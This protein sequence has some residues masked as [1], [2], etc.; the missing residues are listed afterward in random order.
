[1]RG[2]DEHGRGRLCILGITPAH[3]G[4]SC[5]RTSYLLPTRDHPRA[6]GEKASPKNVLRSMAGSPPRMRGKEAA[7]GRFGGSSGIT[8]A[9]AGKRRKRGNGLDASGDHPRACGEK[10]YTS[11]MKTSSGGSPPRMRG[12]A[13]G[14]AAALPLFRITPAHAGKRTRSWRAYG[15]PWEHPRA[16]GEKTLTEED[17]DPNWGSPPRMRGKEENGRAEGPGRGITPAHAGKS[18][19]HGFSV[20]LPKDHPR[21]CGEKL[22]KFYPVIRSQGSPPR[23]R[24]KG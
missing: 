20:L 11:A 2:K 16:C 9:H 14:D 17:F 7:V 23:M 8:P 4:K 3:A 19:S 5:K 1:M 13:E 18:A 15:C 12:K 21:A 24:G 22:T 6:C 10:G